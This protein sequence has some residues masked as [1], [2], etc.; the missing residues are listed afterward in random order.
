M[1][2]WTW[3][4]PLSYL[5]GLDALDGAAEVK[6]KAEL[7]HVFDFVLGVLW[8]ALLLLLFQG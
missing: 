3:P 1:R 6:V 5:M 7:V 4:V 2:L 8:I